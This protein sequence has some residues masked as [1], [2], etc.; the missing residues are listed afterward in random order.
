MPATNKTTK[1]KQPT[2]L[3][4]PACAVILSD[5]ENKKL[6]LDESEMSAEVAFNKFYAD[7]PVVQAVAFKKFKEKLNDHRRQVLKKKE[8]PPQKKLLNGMEPQQKWQ[9]YYEDLP[10]FKDTCFQAFRDWLEKSAMPYAQAWEE[11]C[12]FLPAF[13]DVDLERFKARLKAHQDQVK[14]YMKRSKEEELLMLEEFKWYPKV[15]INADGTPNG[16][17]IQQSFC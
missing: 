5:L 16:P 8:S 13:K 2:C 4:N 7:N 12:K 11:H 9:K 14:K 1:E 15:E 17:C 6:P 3:D 10:K